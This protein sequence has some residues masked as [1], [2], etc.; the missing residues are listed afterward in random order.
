MTTLTLAP[1]E[2]DRTT[3]QLALATTGLL[4][5]E[6][7]PK[8]A[9]GPET[10]PAYA[11]CRCGAMVLTGET[12]DGTRWALDTGIK[13]FAVLWQSGAPWPQLRES[14]AYPIHVCKEVP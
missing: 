1:A 10:P 8:A 7:V 12:A 6:E 9:K 13:T 11:P 5:T 3:R 14:V 4:P 2:G